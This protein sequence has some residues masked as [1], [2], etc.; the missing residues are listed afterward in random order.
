MGGYGGR[1]MESMDGWMAD[2]VCAFLVVWRV[3]S[4]VVCFFREVV[5]ALVHLSSAVLRRVDRVGPV[6]SKARLVA[7]VFEPDPSHLL[8]TT[9]HT[10]THSPTDSFLV[11]FDNGYLYT[12]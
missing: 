11:L 1:R 4:F 9:T 3:S 8:T 10:P 6:P 5:C 2:G 12:I 7:F